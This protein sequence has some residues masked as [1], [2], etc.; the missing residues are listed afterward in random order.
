MNEGGFAI[1]FRQYLGEKGKKNM[2]IQILADQEDERTQNGEF[3][4]EETD[5]GCAFCIIFFI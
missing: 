3:V 2:S 4:H 1:V 5:W